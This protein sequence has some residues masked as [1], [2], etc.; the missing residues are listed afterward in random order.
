MAKYLS[1]FVSVAFILF[2]GLIDYR[3]WESSI[4]NP[5]ASMGAMIAFIFLQIP[6]ILIVGV[7]YLVHNSKKNNSQFLLE[8]LLVVSISSVILLITTVILVNM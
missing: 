7:I 5:S 3:A 6:Y 2:I 1:R 4:T 8:H